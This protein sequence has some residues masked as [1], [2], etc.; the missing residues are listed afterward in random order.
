MHETL[1]LL[2]PYQLLQLLFIVRNIKQTEGD[3]GCFNLISNGATYDI[4][5]KS[6]YKFFEFIKEPDLRLRVIKEDTSY[7]YLHAIKAMREH[8]GKYSATSLHTGLRKLMEDIL[9]EEPKFIPTINGVS[10]SRHID[11]VKSFFKLH[12]L[13]RQNGITFNHEL[14]V[15]YIKAA[16][17]LP[18]YKQKE[19]LYLLEP[20]ILGENVYYEVIKSKDK[21]VDYKLCFNK[22]DQE[23]LYEGVEFA[24]NLLKWLSSVYYINLNAEDDN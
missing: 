20:N 21:I 3:C 6:D 12:L 23:F 10:T 17:L 14:S 2:T 1:K 24:E 8:L 9:G 22:N 19:R 11:E 5:Y 16:M 7:A 4:I 18:T 15:E 13:L